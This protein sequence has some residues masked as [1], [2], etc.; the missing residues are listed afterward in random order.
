MGPVVTSKLAMEYGLDE[1]LLVRLTRRFPYERDWQGFPNNGGYD[2]RLITRLKI[3]YRSV[4][5]ILKLPSSLFYDNELVP[6][7]CFRNSYLKAIIY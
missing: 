5:E 7:V 2:P 3:N 4:P 6:Q 1:S